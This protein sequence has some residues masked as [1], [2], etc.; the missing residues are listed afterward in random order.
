MSS[1]K[2]SK[3]A[4]AIPAARYAD[5]VHD[6]DKARANAAPAGLPQDSVDAIKDALMGAA[7]GAIT[8][9]MLVLSFV[10]L[11]GA[12]HIQ[13]T[14]ATGSPTATGTNEETPMTYEVSR[15]RPRGALVGG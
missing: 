4:W 2:A 8:T 7:S 12:D 14:H 13:L 11:A 15:H 9:S 3:A 6:G 1:Q 10:T 5:A